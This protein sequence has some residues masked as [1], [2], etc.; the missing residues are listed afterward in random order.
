MNQWIALIG[1]IVLCQ[2]VG[3]LGGLFTAQSVNGWYDTL[4]KPVYNPPKSVFGPVWTTLYLLMAIAAWIVWRY[5]DS[6]FAM[7]VFGV[8]LLMNLL[9]SMIFFGMRRPLLAC[10]EL[11]LLWIMVAGTTIFFWSYSP[12]AGFL[13]VPYLAWTTFAFVL[14]GS[15][16][17]LNQNRFSHW[18]SG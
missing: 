10:A 6:G 1:F 7:Q 12:I 14:N 2:A 15:I 3:L 17:A 5:E 4:R 16:V 9:W 13:L 18:V 11:F 8:Q